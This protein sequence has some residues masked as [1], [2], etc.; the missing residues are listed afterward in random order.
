MLGRS[1]LWRSCRTDA[2]SLLIAMA[3]LV[4]ILLPAGEVFAL[5]SGN[6]TGSIDITGVQRDR[7]EGRDESLRQQY[8]VNWQKRFARYLQTNWSMRYYRLNLDQPDFD[9]FWREEVQP[10]FELVYSHPEYSFVGWYRQRRAIGN[11]TTPDLTTDNYS[12]DFKVRH[13]N[14]PIF[15][16]RYDWNRNETDASSL[17]RTLYD[18]RFQATADYVGMVHEFHYTFSIR[19]YRN[20]LS[21][22]KNRLTQH[23]IRYGFQK[24]YL[25]DGRLRIGG[26]YSYSRSSDH[27]DA[28]SGELYYQEIPALLGLYLRTTD[29]FYGALDTLQTLVDGNRSSAASGATNIGQGETAQNFGIDLGS[30]R[31]INAIYVY[32]DRASDAAVS[33]TVYTSTDNLY[34]ERATASTGDNFNFAENRYEIHFAPIHAR[35]IKVVNGGINSVGTV[36]VTEIEALFSSTGNQTN[37]SQTHQLNVTARY[38]VD[39]K[40]TASADIAY[41]GEP[42]GGVSVGRDEYFYAL[43]ARRENSRIFSQTLRWQES[44]QNPHN[45]EHL[46]D[47][48]LIYNA[49]VDPLRTLRFTTSAS[50]RASYIRGNQDYRQHSITVQAYGA[51]LYGL[52][53][54]TESGFSKNKQSLT[55]ITTDTWTYRFSVDAL[56]TRSVKTAFSYGHQTSSSDDNKTTRDLDQ[57][58]LSGNIRLTPKISLRA[59]VDWNYDKYDYISEEYGIG[60]VLTRSFNISGIYRKTSGTESSD[61]ERFVAQ[62]SLKISSRSNLYFNYTKDDLASVAGPAR[63]T[64]QAGFRSSF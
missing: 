58:S 37:V 7:N 47:W 11:S 6:L 20:S 27:I 33:W 60:Y 45:A 64:L 42:A 12:L 22:L 44:F 35:Y 55:S 59:A 26:D 56:L 23:Q 32:T 53:F 28:N 36:Y 17:R 46:S 3:M 57:Y 5:Y 51:P 62:A 63:E 41:R 13:S 50:T 15:D 24:N 48:A 52:N 29:P 43:S 54:S 1:R 30:S 4:F 2:A 19:N 38:R 21:T 8:T 61:Y 18:R 31:R 16:F 25:E 14:W 9:E 10:S 34:W 39:R 40:T 49:N